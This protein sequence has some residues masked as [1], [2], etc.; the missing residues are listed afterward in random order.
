MI[1]E[2]NLRDAEVDNALLIHVGNLKEVRRLDLSGAEIDDEGVLSIA[3]L[4]LRELWLQSTNITDRSAETISKIKTID[5]L[6]LNSNQL[7][8]EFLANLKSMPNLRDLGLR[9]TRVTSDGMA[10]LAR[11]PKL[12]ELDVYHTVVDDAGVESLTECKSLTFIGL[13]MTKITE[14]VFPHLARMPKLTDADL[15]GNRP[16]STDSVLAFERDQP[17]IDIEWYRK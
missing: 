5:F 8:D 14:N 9:G 6:Q 11:H 17:R 1:D 2:V 12:K 4:P 15:T 10:Y 3:H 7:S 16:I 13:S